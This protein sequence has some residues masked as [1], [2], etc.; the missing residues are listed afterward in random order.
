VTSTTST[1]PSNEECHPV[2][3][4]DERITTSFP[5][6]RAGVV[7][8]RGLVN[9]PCPPALLAEYRAE[10]SAVR[11]R[12]DGTAI[13]DRPSIAAWRR[14]FSQ[15]GAKPTQYRNAAEALLR[16]LTKQGGIPS[17]NT[18]V[19]IGNLVSIRYGLPVAVLDLAGIDGPVT[20]RFAEGHER[21]TDLGETEPV[22][23]DPGEVVFVDGSGVAA[24]RRWCWRQ[25]AQSATGPTTVEAIIVVEG[26]HE[27][28][29]EEVVRASADLVALLATHQPGSSTTSWEL[30]PGQAGSPR[31][32][33]AGPPRAGDPAN[34][35]FPSES[36]P[37][38]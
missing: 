31:S 21:F 26:H 11:A 2:F 37:S 33:P 14:A 29:A 4:Y 32:L 23:P 27:T 15:F 5:T 35:L 28:A 34:R 16:R 13:A 19:D 17:I 24:A 18:L 3:A 36:R 8:A 25:S 1:D 30:S 12:M 22:T 6:I 38:R 9:G 10:Q 20:V 7:H